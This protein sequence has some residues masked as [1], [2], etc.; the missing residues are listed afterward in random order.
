MRLLEVLI[1]P[2]Q[3]GVQVTGL[4]RRRKFGRLRQMDGI[5]ES[6]TVTGSLGPSLLKQ[7]WGSLP[8]TELLV[9][10]RLNIQTLS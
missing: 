4:G 5:Y 10:T 3:C 7:A 9:C 2:Y 8:F 6:A 1:S